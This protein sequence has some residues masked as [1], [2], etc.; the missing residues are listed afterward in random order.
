MSDPGD[1]VLRFEVL[2]SL[3]AWRGG[4]ELPLGPLQQRT[5]LAVLLLNAGR[6]LRRERLIEAVWGEEP[7]AYAVN[8]L[9]KHVSGLRRVLEPD[10]SPRTPSSLLSW[11]DTGYLLTVPPERLDLA[12]FDELVETARATRAEGD[13]EG[14]AGAFH[15]ALELWR[16]PLCDGLAGPLLDAERDRL[17][18]RRL[19]VIEQCADLDLRLGRHR[20]LV[21]QLREL[22]G[23]YPFRERLRGLLMLALYGAGRQGEALEAFHEARRYLLDELG[24]EPGPQLRAVHERILNADPGLAAEAAERSPRGSPAPARPGVRG[25]PVPAQLPYGMSHFAGRE[26]QIERLNEVCLRDGAAAGGAV[27]ITAIGGTAGVGKTALAVHWAHQVRDRFP[28]GQ[29]YVNL[30]GFDPGAA[31]MEPAE[32]IRGFLDAFDVEP[33]RIPISL[34]GQAALYRSLLADQRVLVILDNA[35]NAE[36]VRP[37]LPGSPGSVVVVTSRDQMPGLVAAEGAVPLTVDLLSFAEARGL[38]ARRLGEA[39][40]AAE[41]AAVEKIVA[42]CA[43]LPLALAIVAARAAAHPEFALEQLAGE[44]EDGDARLDAFEIADPSTDIRSVFSWSLHRVSPAAQRLFRQLGL[45]AG[46]DI[47]APTAASLAGVSPIRARAALAEL[48]RAHLAIEHVP[49]RFTFHDLLRA[50]AA[51]L[52]M[53]R[54]GADER[55]DAIGRVL[56]HYLQTAFAGDRLINPHRDPPKIAPPDRGVTPVDLRSAEQA[57]SWFTAEHA[58]LLAAVEQALATGADSSCWHLAWAVSTYLDRQGHWNDL[59]TVHRSG[60][61]AAERIGDLAGQALSHRGI[62][63]GFARLN[64]ND[65]ADRHLRAALA[66]FEELGDRVGQAYAH[67]TL[68]AMLDQRDRD[69]EALGH[70]ERALELYR[71]EGHKAGLADALNAVGWFHARVGDYEQALP[72]CQEALALHEELGD[73]GGCAQTW[74]S[75]GYIHH[76]LGAHDEARHCYRQAVTLFA[77]LGDRYNEAASLTRLGDAHD[78]AGERSDAERAWRRALDIFT[79]IGHAE[80]RHPRAR[81]QARA[82]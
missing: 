48:A 44:L 69:L 74:D 16:G 23:R 60:L 4:A 9:Q 22:I 78:A 82:G 45:H 76:N 30:R 2:G 19:D 11:T 8:L 28:D 54:D 81:L 12:A 7:P 3:R 5:V 52:A 47:T 51:E 21:G 36:Q 34:E 68:A 61:L 79:E 18:E 72:C 33:Q 14:A 40:I 26:T 57:M 20:E 80:A 75:L 31:A 38:L 50:Y 59:S 13:Q 6:R 1:P 73:E 56:D 15:R 64:Q 65:V 55:R 67:R 42:R 43:R 41:L 70:A 25:L 77:R 62:A 53:D 32:A 17:G 37:L 10:R 71:A 63:R 29:L 24:I 49:G 27:V 58:A 46:P 66:L 35:E 39:R